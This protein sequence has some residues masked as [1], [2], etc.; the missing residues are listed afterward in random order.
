MRVGDSK[1][2]YG[3]SWDRYEER[4]WSYQEE[5]LDI[6]DFQTALTDLRAD[7]YTSE[8]PTGKEK[9]RFTL[10]LE[11]ENCPKVSVP[12]YRHDGSLCLAEVDGKRYRL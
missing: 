8:K 2:I 11:N 9:I 1:I 7:I 6:T 12:L 10:Y 5:E 3:I 4:V